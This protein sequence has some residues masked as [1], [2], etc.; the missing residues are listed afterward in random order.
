MK[1]DK[2]SQ[3]AKTTVVRKE[4][5]VATDPKMRD[6]YWDE[7]VGYHLGWKRYKR[8]I[9]RLLLFQAR[10]YKTWKHNRRCQWKGR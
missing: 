10:M 1:P 8:G 5:K 2:N 9:R 3:I 6:W 7:G 4:Y